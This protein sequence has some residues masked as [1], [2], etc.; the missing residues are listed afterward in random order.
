MCAT[1]QGLHARARKL[2]TGTAELIYTYVKDGIESSFQ[3]PLDA[4]NLTESAK[5][6]S[7]FSYV[8]GTAAVVIQHPNFLN[9]AVETGA[10]QTMQ[11]M[12]I[13]NY[14]TT[15]PM[16]KGL[17]SSAAVCVLVATAFNM[18]FDLGFSQEELMEIAF[19]VRTPT[20]R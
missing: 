10:Q 13:R 15:L 8:A 1:N 20:Q 18:V 17:S 3:W 6:G 2:A 12:E 9:K 16:K 11:G 5:D 4:N 19:Q 14:K 7:F